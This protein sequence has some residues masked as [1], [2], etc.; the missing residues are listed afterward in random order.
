[1]TGRGKSA[2]AL[3]IA[4]AL[5][6]GNLLF[7]K[8]PVRRTGSVLF[9][10]EE[11]SLSDL[12]DRILKMRISPDLPIF[13]LSFQNILLDNEKSFNSLNDVIGQINPILVIFDSL[14]RL[15]HA[16][17]NEAVEMASVMRKLREIVNQG[18][19]VLVLH[20]HTK[21]DGTL[22]GRARGSSDI[23]GAVDVEYSLYERNGNLLLQTVKSRR[24]P[25]SPM[26]LEIQNTTDEL[27]FKFLG[28]A[29]PRRDEIVNAVI[30]II[31]EKKLSFQE[32]EEAIHNQNIEISGKSL[33]NIIAGM[34]GNR[35]R[36]EHGKYNKKLYFNL[37]SLTKKSCCTDEE[38]RKIFNGEVI[39]S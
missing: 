34:V 18:I 5:A 32:I 23:I 7:G 12:R 25:I 20:H 8:F 3:A 33:R 28:D 31:A 4:H 11:N 19:G 21:G 9:I 17:E 6:S 38:I 35:L 1:Y 39:S 14:I 24:M 22:E 15:H 26:R 13:F 27:Y 16:R 36:E 29:I 2:L 37:E 30:S 10:D